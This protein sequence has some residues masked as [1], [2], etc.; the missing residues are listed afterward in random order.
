MVRRN[1]CRLL[2]HRHEV[3]KHSVVLACRIEV[4]HLTVRCLLLAVTTNSENFALT[5]LPRPVTIP[6]STSTLR[7]GREPLLPRSQQS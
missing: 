6:S 5:M 3:G 7:C 4:V 1:Q 2:H